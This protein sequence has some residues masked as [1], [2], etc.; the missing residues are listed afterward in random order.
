[1]QQITEF[2]LN[3]LGMGDTWTNGTESALK[4]DLTDQCIKPVLLRL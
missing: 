4:E 3:V 1:M 2:S